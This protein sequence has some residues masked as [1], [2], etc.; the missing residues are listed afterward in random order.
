MALVQSSVLKD[1]KASERIRRYDF[2][3]GMARGFILPFFFNALA[4]L[5]LDLTGQL[6]A[7]PL[8]H[9]IPAVFIVF[10]ILSGLA[11]A[12]F[13]RKFSGALLCQFSEQEPAP[14]TPAPSSSRN[15]RRGGHRPRPQQSKPS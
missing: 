9:A 3:A 1:G 11:A 13:I 4:F 5:Y 14:R 10:S 12:G 7:H 6:G 2:M 15:R 8:R